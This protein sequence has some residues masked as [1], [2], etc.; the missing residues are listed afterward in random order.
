MKTKETW[1]EI[2]HSRGYFV[3]ED[4][5]RACR[6]LGWRAAI[7]AHEIVIH[8]DETSRYPKEQHGIE[9]AIGDMV[10]EIERRREDDARKAIFDDDEQLQELTSALHELEEL[11]K[12][13][14]G[15][16]NAYTQ[17]QR[18]KEAIFAREA[19]LEALISYNRYSGDP[20]DYL[21]DYNPYSGT[22]EV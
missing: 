20:G 1:Q 19:A 4:I 14:G 13:I 21:D 10:A 15:D 8:G 12:R 2:A 11:D 3:I 18:I 6:D 17:V 9:D 22:Y 7:T 5:G 16:E